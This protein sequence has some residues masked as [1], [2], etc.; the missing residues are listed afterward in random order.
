[1]VDAGLRLMRLGLDLINM[2]KL[3]YIY[4]RTGVRLAVDANQSLA[5]SL[6][7]STYT[8]GVS[9][10]ARLNESSESATPSTLS[11]EQEDLLL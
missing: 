3:F 1:M 5:H 6:T 9:L 7:H 10:L 8:L 2:G 11:L 4:V